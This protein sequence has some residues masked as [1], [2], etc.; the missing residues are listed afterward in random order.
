MIV[1]ENIGNGLVKTYSDQ[2]VMIR[3]GNPESLYDEAI[4]PASAGRTYE[5][6]DI[7]IEDRR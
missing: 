1:Q 3:G 7:P 5:E 6:T 4:D 2:G